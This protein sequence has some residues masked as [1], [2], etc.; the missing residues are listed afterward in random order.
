LECDGFLFNRQSPF[1]IFVDIQILVY[2][3]IYNANRFPDIPLRVV[4][5]DEEEWGLNENCNGEFP[6]NI[7]SFG[8]EEPD[9]YTF[10]NV[11]EYA[12]ECGQSRLWGGIH[13][14]AAIPAGEELCAGLGAQSY[15]LLTVLENGSDYGGNKHYKGGP[16][17]ACGECKFGCSKKDQKDNQLGE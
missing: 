15:D 8:C 17:P 5:G 16:R 9:Q 3:D 1:S 7:G 2:K 4:I 6:S 14:E 10:S 12:H 11:W 13:F